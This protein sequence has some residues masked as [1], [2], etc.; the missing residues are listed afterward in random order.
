MFWAS[1][2][3]RCGIVTLVLAFAV[4]L[5]PTL[6]FAAGLLPSMPTVA[7]VEA[8]VHGSDPDDTAARQSMAFRVLY[9]L[10]VQTTPGGFG[11]GLGPADRKRMDEYSQAEVALA[12]KATIQALKRY[13]NHNDLSPVPSNDFRD[14]IIELFALRPAIAAAKGQADA[15]QAPGTGSSTPLLTE[16][17]PYVGILAL[18]VVM[19]LAAF[20]GMAGVRRKNR[21]I[22][23]EAFQRRNAQGV[24]EFRT[25]EE[26]ES[27][28]N[29]KPDSDMQGCGLVV[30]LLAGLFLV[31]VGGG[32]VYLKLTGFKV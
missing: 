13:Q 28:R 29:R 10:F 6:A 17:L 23:K 9:G 24:L 19:V 14:E 26:A 2:K 16:L 15:T 5:I 11:G 32:V 25:F 22:R 27:F 12:R 20:S 7:Q 3:T 4:L 1:F 21:D 8:K 18:G 30:A 31:L